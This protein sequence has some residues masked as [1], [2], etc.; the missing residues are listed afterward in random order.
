MPRSQT[1]LRML[2]ARRMGWLAIALIAVVVAVSLTACKPEVGADGA[3]LQ[4]HHG[5]SAGPADKNAVSASVTPTVLDATKIAPTKG[6]SFFSAPSDAHQTILKVIQQAKTSLDIVNYRLSDPDV[7]KALKIAAG[8]GVAVRVIL[9]QGILDQQDTLLK[10]NNAT[11]LSD[12]LTAAK[13]L[14]KPSPKGFPISHQQTVVADGQTALITS[15][16]LV[17]SDVYQVT[18][19]FGLETQDKDVIADM[20]LVFDLDWSN[21]GSSKSDTPRTGDKTSRLIW[22]PIAAANGSK[23]KILGL[24]DSAKETIHVETEYL[25]DGDVIKHLLDMANKGVSVSVLTP[26]CVA[27]RKNPLLNRTL[28]N[29]LSS[30]Q[31]QNKVSAAPPTVKSPYIHG[32][33]ILVDGTTFFIGSESLSVVALTK[34]RELGILTS[35]VTMG[36]ILEAQFQSDWVNA[37]NPSDVTKAN[38]E[39][40]TGPYADDNPDLPATSDQPDPLADPKKTPHNGHR[41]GVTTTPEAGAKP[42]TQ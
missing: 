37:L 2:Q 9:D 14:V 24:I 17:T 31:N 34:S 29:Q 6:D 38:C 20:K 30:P 10:K 33:M 41:I 11:S 25:S 19:D 18:R 27:G 15:M 36:N 26:G 12:D 28:V 3:K 8:N 23:A 7:I 35:D 4:G 32:K 13:V 16:D 5:G 21:S 40:V 39:G 42:V 1:S 22:S